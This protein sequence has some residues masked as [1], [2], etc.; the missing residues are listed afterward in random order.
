VKPSKTLSIPRG[1]IFRAIY[2]YLRHSMRLFLLGYDSAVMGIRTQ[3]FRGNMLSS[4]HG[5]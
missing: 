2:V 5:R 1:F 4:F 3:A